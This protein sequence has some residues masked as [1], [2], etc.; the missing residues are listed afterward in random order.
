MWYCAHVDDDPWQA[1]EGGGIGQYWCQF[2]LPPK[3]DG[4]AI[5][6]YDF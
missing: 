4:D 1:I 5:N 6:K 3:S 2:A